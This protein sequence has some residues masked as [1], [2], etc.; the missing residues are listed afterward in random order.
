[1][2]VGW[3]QDLAPASGRNDTE[4]RVN[5]WPFK[6]NQPANRHQTGVLMFSATRQADDQ[7]QDA[8]EC[9]PEVN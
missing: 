2:P 9:H 6:Q 1:M 3:S 7:K 4:P 8:A 5:G